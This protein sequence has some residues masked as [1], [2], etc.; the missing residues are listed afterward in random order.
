MLSITSLIELKI[1][2]SAYLIIDIHFIKSPNDMIC[3]NPGYLKVS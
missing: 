1:C 2:K 3:N